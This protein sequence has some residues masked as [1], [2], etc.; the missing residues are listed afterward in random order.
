MDGFIALVADLLIENGVAPTCV[1]RTAKR[2]LALPGFFRPTKDWD[3]VIVH[4]ERLLAAAE[5]KSQVGSFGNN[6]NNRTEEAL[7]NAT[8][9]WTA[10]R[11]GAFQKIPR[12]WLGFMM[13]LERAPGS[14]SP[15]RVRTPHFKIFAEFQDASYAIRYQL[16]CQKL[17]AERLYDATCFMLTDQ[18]GSYDEPIEEIGF[19]PFVK[20]LVAHVTG[21]LRTEDEMS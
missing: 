6:Y 15:V 13:L 9:I 7:G 18:K 16:L 20:S 3:L 1:F 8:D 17:V 11:E 2:D 14:T 12:P 4:R 5:F 19:A 21:I 10:Y